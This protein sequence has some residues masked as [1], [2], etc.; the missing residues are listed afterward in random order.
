MET[1]HELQRTPTEEISK[2]DVAS[3]LSQLEMA[4]TP[5]RSASAFAIAMTPCVEL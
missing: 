5:P 3:F 1:L 2:E 4:L